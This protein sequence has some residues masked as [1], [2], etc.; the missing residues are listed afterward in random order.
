MSDETLSIYIVLRTLD[1]TLEHIKETLQRFKVNVE[2]QV[3][4][5]RSTNAPPKDPKGTG[6]ASDDVF[7]EEII[8]K[9][10]LDVLKVPPV[11]EIGRSNVE[12]S[13][14]TILV[15]ELSTLLGRSRGRLRAP[16]V[17]I[18]TNTNLQAS[19]SV[20]DENIND[21]YLPS[22]APASANLLEPLNNFSN[23]NISLPSDRFTHFFPSTRVSEGKSLKIKTEKSRRYKILPALTARIRYAKLNANPNMSAVIA[24]LDTEMAP[25]IPNGIVI[26]SVDLDLENGETEDLGR[27]I[28]PP[29][30]QLCHSRDILSFVF[31]L[32]PNT[33]GT[34]TVPSKH[35]AVRGGLD[36]SIIA[37]VLSS[38]I[39]R[40]KIVMRWHTEVDFS[41]AP[42]AHY[43]A[44]RQSILQ[45]KRPPS[46]TDTDNTNPIQ[47]GSSATAGT[48][49]S[50]SP[51]VD[52]GITVTLS[53]PK[54]KL[55]CGKTFTWNIFVVNKSTESRRLTIGVTPVP[56]ARAKH[57]AKESNTLA[58]LHAGEREMVQANIPAQVI[59]FSTDI[60]IGPLAP[61][62]CQ[63]TSLKLLPLKVGILRLEGIR[64]TDVVANEYTDIR[65]DDL[66][67][68]IV[69][70]EAE[71]SRL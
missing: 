34:S 67:D 3:V 59:S 43:V 50:R 16:F 24:A 52:L 45:S 48:S 58:A 31:R 27:R 71:D 22:L 2:V 41:T 63:E 35:T 15:W 5:S 17:L 62:S 33:R 30:P 25:G 10:S 69:E 65:Q 60:K 66:P 55:I 14:S 4:D 36:I 11:F 13:L 19:S 21:P 64:I 61:G 51:D 49:W 37:T 7:T 32:S 40:P 46:S 29:G 28:M 6:R 26:E 1:Y 57:A 44:P 54:G 53:A 9:G 70:S 18:K 68:I 47:Y 20:T 8:W 39:C 23:L 42:N 12:G 38:S 56:T